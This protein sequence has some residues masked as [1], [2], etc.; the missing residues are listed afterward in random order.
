MRSKVL[1]ERDVQMQKFT[2]ERL[3]VSRPGET[4]ACLGAKVY[5]SFNDGIKTVAH[6]VEVHV[7]VR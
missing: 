1:G 7:E 3:T 6:G 4:I 5:V 2:G